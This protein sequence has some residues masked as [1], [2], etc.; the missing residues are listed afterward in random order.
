MISENRATVAEIEDRLMNT[1]D[2]VSTPPL[3]TYPNG[4]H[5][6]QQVGEEPLHQEDRR[7]EQRP[8]NGG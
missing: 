2:S 6:Q 3:S 8:G 5:R 1:T 4:F 7:T